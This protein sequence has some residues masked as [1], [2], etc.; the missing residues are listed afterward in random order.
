M[1]AI[2]LIVGK[3]LEHEVTRR[4]K[5]RHFGFWQSVSIVLFLSKRIVNSSGKTG[6]VVD[7]EYGK[8]SKK[9]AYSVRLD[10]G[11][12]GVFFREHIDF[13]SS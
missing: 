13:V 1:R 12:T 5:V 3:I 2:H 11:T 7:A 9:V 8:F 6:I 4:V 10:D